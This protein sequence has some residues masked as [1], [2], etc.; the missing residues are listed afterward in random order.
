MFFLYIIRKL[1]GRRSGS[2]A[3]SPWSIV[4]NFLMMYK[5][6]MVTYEPL[7]VVGACVSWNYPLH[8]FIHWVDRLLS[9]PD[10]A[11]DHS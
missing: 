8:N 3:F 5:K 11:S 4:P 1:V 2:S 10:R 6:N 7:G 9:A